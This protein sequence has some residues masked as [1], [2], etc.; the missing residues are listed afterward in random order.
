MLCQS[1]LPLRDLCI[2]TQSS[3]DFHKECGKYSLF[4]LIFQALRNVVDAVIKTIRQIECNDT[5]EA[6]WIGK[7]QNVHILVRALD[8]MQYKSYKIR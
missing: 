3:I 5:L 8:E 2:N 4:P 7:N 6:S 1:I